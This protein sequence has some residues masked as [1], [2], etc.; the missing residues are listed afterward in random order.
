MPK[1]KAGA[2]SALPGVAWR[3]GLVMV[4]VL[5]VAIGVVQL[6]AAERW[7][8]ADAGLTLIRSTKE[9]PGTAVV[10]EFATTSGL[11]D[12][13]SYCDADS[14]EMAGIFWRELAQLRR[15]KKAMA[16]AAFDLA[17]REVNA[18]QRVTCNPTDGLAWADLA[19]TALARAGW[20]DTVARQ[21][22]MS[23]K[24]APFEGVALSMR[25]R[26]LSSQFSTGA[27]AADAGLEAVFA[28]DLDA[29][30]AYAAPEALAAAL[31][32]LPRT[33][34]PRARELA[35]AL[36]AGRRETVESLIANRQDGGAN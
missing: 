11:A 23:H 31:S 12:S 25:L 26:L 32:A 3:L 9:A 13:S 34:A 7:S 29:T 5:C 17:Q 24:Y 28:R 27:T 35:L 33:W 21:L 6:Q 14:L 22:Q 18:L 19:D 30:L 16:A 8:L 1:K 10:R 2:G 4:S 20:S 36:P 15:E